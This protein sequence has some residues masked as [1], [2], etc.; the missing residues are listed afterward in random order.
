M[1]LKEQS[2][3]LFSVAE[4]RKILENF[5]ITSTALWEVEDTPKGFTI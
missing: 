1:I 5:I 2:E 3:A 4:H